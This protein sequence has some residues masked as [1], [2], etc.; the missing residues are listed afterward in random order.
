M[1][2]GDNATTAR[3]VAARRS[4]R[5]APVMD[6]PRN[7]WLRALRIYLGV[8]V[9]LHLVWELGQLPLYTIWRDGT[10]REIATAIVHCTAGDLMIA[11]LSLVMSLL[12][13]GNRSWPRECFLIVLTSM[14]LIGAGYTIYSEWL[15]TVVRKSW[16]YTP[17]MPT[18][19]WIGVGLSPLMQWLIVPSAAMLAAGR[20]LGSIFKRK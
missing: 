12:L 11:A 4:K 8:S 17:L 7:N 16:T 2:T 19:P 3:A 14:L 5:D 1:L 18:L 15:N 6:D 13:F 9:V 10:A 20:D